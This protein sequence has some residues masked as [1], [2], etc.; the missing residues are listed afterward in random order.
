[1][2]ISFGIWLTM[3]GAALIA[4]VSLSSKALGQD[5]NGAVDYFGEIEGGVR[6]LADRPQRQDRAKFEEY[7]DLDTGAIL[8]HLHLGAAANDGSFLFELWA[9][10]AGWDDQ[11]YRG[12][13]SKPG[14]AY[15]TLDWDEIPHVTSTSALTLFD[16]SD[17]AALTVSD[18]V[19]AALQA[20]PASANLTTI[21]NNVQPIEL[22]TQ[23]DTGKVGIRYT[24]GPAW[25]FQL[26]HTS[27]KIDGIQALGTSNNGFTGAVELPAPV[28]F[29][30]ENI[31]FS[32]Q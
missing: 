10:N 11:H 4:P 1:M 7:R 20:G 16:T 29:R 12:E 22:K 31:D 9:E 25:D 28:S 18:T 15:L 13:F 14:K 5:Q 6:I 17:P 32:G 21:N 27:Q 2:K 24:P 8:D 30:T 23:R 26:N 19:R 3:A